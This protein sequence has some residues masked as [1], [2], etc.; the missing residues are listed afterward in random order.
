MEYILKNVDAMTHG[1][2]SSVA[3]ALD[4]NGL[5]GCCMLSLVNCRGSDVSTYPSIELTAPE[6]GHYVST[7][8]SIELTAP[9][10]ALR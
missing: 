6:R 9:E 5:S 10:S 2:L 4:N 7:Y 3:V 8:P 1:Y